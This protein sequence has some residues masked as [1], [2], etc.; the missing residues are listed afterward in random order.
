MTTPTPAAERI[1]ALLEGAAAEAVLEAAAEVA[2][3][4]RLPL[5]G[6]IIEDA[7]LLSSAGL[8][9]AREVGGVS[10]RLRRL[11]SDELEVRM[12]AEQERLRALLAET[13]RRHGI[14]AELEIDRGQRVQTVLARLVPSDTLVVRRVAALERPLALVERVLVDARCAVLVTGARSPLLAGR[15]APM[16][17]VED[18]ASAARVVAPAAELSRGQ[19]R[20]VLVL[21]GP[22]DP[23]RAAA[24]R[25]AAYLAEQGLGAVSI[26]LSRLDATAVL[27]AVRR[28]RPALLCVARD[29]ALLAGPDGEYLAE[30]EDVMLAIVP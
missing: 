16:A 30:T 19:Y 2:A 13:A 11:R 21:H 1:L 9:F 24:A 14:V 27:A 15:G 26:E 29:S 22:G 17:L 3:V 10:G 8:P 6:L 20:G 28:E 4:R 18:E 7:E 25:A 23:G 5:V 12:H